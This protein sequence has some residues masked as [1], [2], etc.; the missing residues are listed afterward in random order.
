MKAPLINGVPALRRCADCP[1]CNGNGVTWQGHEC[2]D[3]EGTGCS[4]FPWCGQD[5]DVSFP[6]N[7]ARET[8]T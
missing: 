3:C 4:S 1:E 5:H 6:W 8:G 2:W 7:D